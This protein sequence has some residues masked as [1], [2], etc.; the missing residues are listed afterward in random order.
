[1]A[2]QVAAEADALAGEAR[3]W[4]ETYRAAEDAL[5]AAARRGAAGLL[6][7]N[8]GAAGL[9]PENLGLSLDGG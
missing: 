5:V 9:L 6:P 8:S 3:R 7:E 2:D 1:M 4:R